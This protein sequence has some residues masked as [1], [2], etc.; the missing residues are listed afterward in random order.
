[1]ESERQEIANPAVKDM[2]GLIR[3][4]QKRLNSLRERLGKAKEALNKNGSPRQ[5]SRR[6]RLKQDIANKEAEVERLQ[7][8]KRELPETV[9]VSALEDYK[10]FKR[11][12]T[13]GKNL[14]DFVTSSVWNA[15]KQMVEWLRPVFDNDNE[16][17]DL[18]YA[19]T[20]CH[21]WIKSTP[22]EVI[23]RLEP[24]EQ[25]RRRA[26]QEQLCRKLTGLLAQTPTGKWLIISVGKSPIRN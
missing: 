3:R 24:L 14:F 2:Q 6:E 10:S 25:P 12:D 4:L 20:D 21:G 22:S 9:D 13:E 7:R 15:R 26:A 8:E 5:N 1:M 18:F 11:I 17:V 23:V 16:V 19:I